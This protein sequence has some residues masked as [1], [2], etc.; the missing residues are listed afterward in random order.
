MFMS[1]PERNHSAL[2][3]DARLHALLDTAGCIG[4]RTYAN[5]TWRDWKE[6]EWPWYGICPNEEG[7]FMLVDL[8]NHAGTKV[9]GPG[10]FV[11]REAAREWMEKNLAP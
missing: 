7:G 11:T 8:Y 6:C 9:T 2:M 1:N 3:G 4:S 10:N 5:A